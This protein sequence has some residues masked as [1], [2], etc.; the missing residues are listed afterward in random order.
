MNCR[1]ILGLLFVFMTGCNTPDNRLEIGDCIAIKDAGDL[2]KVTAVGKHSFEV[3]A[4]S[5]GAEY[6]LAYKDTSAT[7]MKVDCFDWFDKTPGLK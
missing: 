6:L 4:R 2:F 5:N 1:A 3:V 7:F